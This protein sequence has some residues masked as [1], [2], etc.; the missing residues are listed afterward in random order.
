M[1]GLLLKHPFFH[2]CLEFVSVRLPGC[3]C[4]VAQLR[5]DVPWKNPGTMRLLRSAWEM[6]GSEISDDTLVF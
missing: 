5:Q 1:K 4:P 2:W 6:V 3:F